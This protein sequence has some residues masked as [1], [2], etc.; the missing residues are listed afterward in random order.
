MAGRAKMVSHTT[1]LEYGRKWSTGA[2]IQA[3]AIGKIMEAEGYRYITDGF[4]LQQIS[5]TT[6]QTLLGT[7]QRHSIHSI[8]LTMT[9]AT[10][11]VIFDGQ[12]RASKIETDE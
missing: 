3:P 10:S 2:T 5:S 4:A 6:S 12:R 11:Q 1:C 8:A 9:E 7:G